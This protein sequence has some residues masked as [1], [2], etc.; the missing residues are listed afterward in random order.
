MII[1]RVVGNSMLPYL[2]P[3]NIV[4]VK[5]VKK[6]KIGDIVIANVNNRQ[7]IKRVKNINNNLYELIGDNKNESTDSRSFGMVQST[8]IKGVVFKSYNF[9]K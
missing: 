4:L 7:V 5:K 8:D 3:G 6:Y 1:R 9:F 2:K